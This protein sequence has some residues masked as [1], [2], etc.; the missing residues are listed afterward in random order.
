MG[1]VLLGI[2]TLNV[3]GLTGAVMQMLAHGLT[4]GLLFLVVGL[5]YQRTHS[6]DLADYGSLLGKAPRFAFFIAFGLLAAIGLPGSAGFIA[7]LHVL[8]GGFSRWGGW[9]LLLG[10]AM[11]IGAA[12]S[13][14]VI[15]RLC[16]KGPAMELPDMTRTEGVAAGL[17][18]TCILAL[19]IWPAPLLELIAGSVGQVARLFGT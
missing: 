17:L 2:A 9:I 1:V 13:L 18:A 14:R 7:E 5:L 19:G 6:R 15:G 3:T 8:V 4:A 16:L 12:Y 11:L 10:I